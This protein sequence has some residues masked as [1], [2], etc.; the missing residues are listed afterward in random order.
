[1]VKIIVA[2]ASDEKCAHFAGVLEE[3]GHTVFRRCTSGSEVRRALNQYD[4]SI[5][6]CACRLGDCTADELAWDMN[7]KALMLAVGRPQQ[8]QNCEHP[9]IFKL[10]LPCSKGEINSAVGM[11]IQLHQKRAPRRSREQEA[12]IDLAKQALIKH[13]GM[14]EVQA[15][16]YLQRG[17]MNR[18]MKMIDYAALILENAR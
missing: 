14:D 18:G 17:A 13:R 16:R 9:N 11:L 15:H 12:Q 4:D 8:L 6:V 10:T 3:A 2:F 5:V 7:E 1:M